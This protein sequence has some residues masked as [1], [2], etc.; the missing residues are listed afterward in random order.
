MGET[1]PLLPVIFA[2]LGL[3][4]AAC[5]S[6][7][8]APTRTTQP[9]ASAPADSTS[10]AQ[11]Y[12]KAWTWQN[13]NPRVWQ[14]VGLHGDRV[15]VAWGG[16]YDPSSSA[17]GHPGGLTTLASASGAVGWEV[18]T[19]SQAFPPAFADKL[20]ILGTGEGTVLGIDEATGAERWRTTFPG[21][22]LWVVSLGNGLVAVADGDPEDIGPGGLVDKMRLAGRVWGLDTATG[23]VKWRAAVGAFRTFVV[24]TPAGLAVAAPDNR[25]GGDVALLDPA[26]GTVKWQVTTEY[27][28]AAPAVAGEL[29][30]V[31]GAGSMVALRLADGQETWRASPVNGGT[32][33]SIIVQG[34]EFISASNTHTIERRKAADGSLVQSSQF[35]DCGFLAIASSPFA[36]A[37]GSLARVGPGTSPFG[38]EPVYSARDGQVQS[39]AVDGQTLV[40]SEETRFGDPP[41]VVGFRAGP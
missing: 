21:V 28:A 40:L 5:G 13:P 14:W 37:S 1:R 6:G 41:K 26:T 12:T 22:P 33:T 18:K 20:A 17:P 31:P 10:A 11:T 29:L 34:S 8:S 24:L 30:L 2:V 36:I 32:F 16:K 23:Q 35:P 3:V 15:F 4:L 38:L 27:A 9:D 7:N 19:P 39:A 25:G